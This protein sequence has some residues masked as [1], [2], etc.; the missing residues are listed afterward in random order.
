MRLDPAGVPLLNRGRRALRARCVLAAVSGLALLLAA[1]CGNSGSPGGAVSSTVVI[2]AVPGVSDAA[3]Y[4]AQKDG[5]FAAEGL[6]HVRIENEP[7]QAAVVNALQ[8]SHPVADIGASDYG[9]IFY[10]Q[11]QSHDL[12]ILADGYDATAGSLEILTLPGSSITSPA[13]L[14]STNVTVGMPSDDIV[15]A[16]KKAP[17]AG[18]PASLDQAAAIQV[19]KNYVGN[20]AGSV[21]WKVESQQQEVKD[22]GSHKL[23]AILVSEPYIY[24]AESKLGATEVL[25]AFSGETAGLPL[26]GYV[27]L[28]AW[29]GQNPGAVADFQAAIAKAQAEASLAG[30]VQGVLHSSAGMSVQDADLITVG[31]YPTS[32]SIEK[33]QSVVLLMGSGNG[34]M[35]NT[36]DAAVSRRLNI[37]PMLVG[38]SN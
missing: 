15:T 4:L 24:Q 14:V 3:I 36:N 28:N 7:S 6:Q 12:R 16:L 29:V 33:L 26:L 9:N 19:L 38:P 30:Q 17:S 34:S 2:A 5:L 32:T 13:G 35:V 11:A 1:G 37:K 8:N 21:K 18:Q 27:A 20:A 23:Q 10:A 25:D 31:T 22:L